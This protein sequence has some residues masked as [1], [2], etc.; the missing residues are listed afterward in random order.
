MANNRTKKL[1]G[2]SLKKLMAAKPIERISVQQICDQCGLHR[3]TFYYHFETKYDLLNWTFHYDCI[4]PI[5]EGDYPDF[6]S[7]FESI[8]RCIDC[9]R[10][11]FTNAFRVAPT[12][13]FGNTFSNSFQNFFIEQVKVLFKRFVRPNYQQPRYVEP[14]EFE[15]YYPDTVAVSLMGNV[16]QWLL[17]HPELTVEQYLELLHDFLGRWNLASVPQA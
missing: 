16:Q 8:V 7:A 1:L 5:L 3:K 14:R 12:T 10:P 17:E 13:S 2:D 4:E 15:T 9:Q 11:F 6:E